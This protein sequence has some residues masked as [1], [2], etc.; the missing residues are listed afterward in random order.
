[1]ITDTHLDELKILFVKHGV[2]LAYLF[3]SQAEGLARRDSDVDVAVLLQSDIPRGQYFDVR[4]SLTN[5]L[6]SLFHRNEIDVV[7]L[8]DSTALLAY[9]I[10]QHG[11]VLYEDEQTRP[12]V[13]FIVAATLHY[14]DTHHFRRL[15]LEYLSE[16]VTQYALQRT[17][18][19]LREKRDD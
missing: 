17:E 3:G 8:N 18:R 14:A 13:D 11:V 6:I 16:D 9:E 4:L 19:A 12:Q 7:I 5:E 1:M 15:A 10:M 2:V